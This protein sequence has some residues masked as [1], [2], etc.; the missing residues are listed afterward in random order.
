[1][2]MRDGEVRYKSSFGFSKVNDLREMTRF[3]VQE[4]TTLYEPY[5]QVTSTHTAPLP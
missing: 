1:M 4:H 2:D 5:M 3:F